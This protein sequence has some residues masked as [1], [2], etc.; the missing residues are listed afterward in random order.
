MSMKPT[1]VTDLNKAWL[2]RRESQKGISI[3][4]EYHLVL[5]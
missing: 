2:K 5:N 1:K 4:P 3:N